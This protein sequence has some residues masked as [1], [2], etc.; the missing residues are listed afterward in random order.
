VTT[1]RQVLDETTNEWLLGTYRDIINALQNDIDDTTPNITMQLAFKSIGVGSFIAIDDE[2][3]Y[4]HDVNEASK[5]LQVIRGIRGSTPAAHTAGTQAF[6]NP[7]FSLFVMRSAMRSEIRSWPRSLYR[8]G[9]ITFTGTNDTWSYDLSDSQYFLAVLSVTRDD[10]ASPGRVLE[11]SRWR[12]ENGILH[13]AAPFAG[14]Y[15]VKVARRFAIDNLADDVDL[16]SNVGLTEGML[17][18]CKI[19]IAWRLYTGREGIRLQV[20][21]QGE[22]RK[23]EEVPVQATVTYGRQLKA[24]RD[25]AIGKE[26]MNLIHLHGVK[27][28]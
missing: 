7:R 21:A 20:D 17:E 8:V 28:I 1:V 15:T 2:L 9:E 27:E 16:E 4:V 22:S 13:F 23:A 19:G 18:I 25:E 12:Q 10:S 26:S 11:V 3:M 14:N 6:I 24:M 5:T